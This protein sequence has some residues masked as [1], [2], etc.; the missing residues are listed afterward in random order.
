MLA[1]AENSI[2]GTFDP[3]W[4]VLSYLV[5]VLASFTALDL[6]GRIREH[7]GWAKALWIS[8][9][10][11]TLGGGVWSMHF[12]G[13]LALKL[14]VDVQYDPG[15]T[16]LSFAFVALSAGCAFI[17]YTALQTLSLRIGLGSLLLGGGIAAMHYSGMAAMRM[18]TQ[19][20]LPLAGGSILI[21]I[22]ASAAALWLFH[23]FNEKN[24]QIPF[25]H[26]VLTAA[27]MG[28]AVVG[29]H[30]TGMAAADFY[31]TGP[32]PQAPKE[33]LDAQKLAGIVSIVTL[34]IFAVSLVVS[35]FSKK[36]VRLEKSRHGLKHS[37]DR[38]ET[39]LKDAEE[40]FAK[41]SLERRKIERSLR[42]SRERV[43]FIMDN[44]MEGIITIDENSII[45]SFNPAAGKIFGYDS[46]ELLGQ[47]ITQLMPE[48]YRDSHLQAVE[49]Y[50][51]TGTA[52]ILGSSA[53]VEGLRK[54]GS[55]FP[56]ELS[57]SKIDR[58]GYPVFIAT[59]RDITDRKRMEESLIEDKKSAEEANR[60][61]SEFLSRMSHE[62]RTPMNAILGF[63]QLMEL[64]TDEPLTASQE[65]RLKEILTAGNH[66]LE[67]INEVLDLSRIE[68]GK[69]TLSIENVDLLDALEETLT[70]VFPMA[71]E[72]GVIIENNL[73]GRPVVR[74]DRT[75]LK[76]VLLN[77]LSNAVK[78]NRDGGRV[79]LNQRTTPDGNIGI[80]VRDT[81][82]G[83]SQEQLEDIFEPFNRL[84]A[85]KTDIE[86]T[87]I[88]LTITRRLLDQMNGGIEVNSTPGEGSTF[89]LTLPEG[90]VTALPENAAPAHSE[91]SNGGGDTRVHK[92]L[93]V[94]DNPANL[95]LIEQI[96][97]LRKDITL[98]KAP[99]AQIG[100]DLARAHR[101]D[102]I[103]MDINLPEMDGIEAF[104]RLRSH[105]ET[106]DIP[107][108]AVSAN[109][110]E[111]DVKKTLSAGFRSYIKKPF[112]LP[113]FLEE[114][115]G[116]L[117]TEKPTRLQTS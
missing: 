67:L 98:L 7:S 79:T 29:M 36:W 113:A 34:F 73:R 60:A 116:I 59:L 65:E 108:I 95:S 38:R 111:S 117:K 102:L 84:D 83:I 66:L 39:L 44:V 101:P 107:V 114:V 68:S 89:I 27:I 40:L 99:Q 82:F 55:V 46:F 16:F 45:E 22:A 24:R 10:A 13:M 11:L 69:L 32:T 81:G 56:L 97:K 90:E 20:H 30:Y 109:A 4:V 105:E 96:F 41:G 1:A 58:S 71:G 64:D 5:A 77:L 42:D 2:Q 100:I 18:E 91:G 115:Y 47:S 86:G 14:P 78:Y 80:E 26:R 61:K 31:P 103:L 87:G 54:D 3:W 110:M 75:K 19:Y 48:S 94:E 74:A 25:R 62:L 50:L 9:G 63:G 106:R 21:A 35:Y 37:I 104:R 15:T 85:E 28:V 51:K 93:Y 112:N 92:V 53:E 8:G 17:I 49:R 72:K 23:L 88:G 57:L 52:K 12:I 76:Q 43:R 70:L 33:T 6:A